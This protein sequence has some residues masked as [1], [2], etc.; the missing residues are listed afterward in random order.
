VRFEEV[1]GK[2]TTTEHVEV[3]R[4]QTSHPDGMRKDQAEARMDLTGQVVNVSEN[5]ADPGGSKEGDTDLSPSLALSRSLTSHPGGMRED[6]TE[7]QMDLTSRVVNVSENFVGPGGLKEGDTD[8]SLSLAL[9][10]SLRLGNPA[11]ETTH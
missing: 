9:S 3:D 4:K 11:Y 6:Q 2:H 8:L 7:A 5:L 10:R 1:T